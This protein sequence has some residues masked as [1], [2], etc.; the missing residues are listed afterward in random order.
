MSCSRPPCASDG[1]ARATHHLPPFA[2]ERLGHRLAGATRAH[3]AGL[4]ARRGSTPISLRS[5]TGYCERTSLGVSTSY[6]M[7]IV[8]QFF[9]V[10]FM[11]GSQSLR[12]IRSPVVWKTFACIVRPNS[13]S[14]A[15]HRLIASV[16]HR[17]QST[18]CGRSPYD[19]RTPRVSSPDVD[20]ELPG[21]HVS[22]SVTRAPIFR[23]WYAVHPPNAPA[24][25][26]AMSGDFWPMTA[27]ARRGAGAAA[28]AAARARPP[29]TQRR[30]AIRSGR[31]RP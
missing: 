22:M 27:G 7:P 16:A 1:N 8:S 15:F 21:P 2:L 30:R 6:L 31:R 20:R 14:H 10:S 26:T 19:V 29:L 3:D 11:Y 23:R 13:S 12:K 28:A 24:P 17:A 4:A 18:P 25:M 5:I 9:R